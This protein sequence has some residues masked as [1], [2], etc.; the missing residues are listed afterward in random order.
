[1]SQQF[2]IPQTTRGPYDA[3][4][5]EGQVNFDVPFIVFDGADLQVRIKPVG[6]TVFGP[7]LLFGVDFTVSQLAIP[8]G[9][10]LSLSVGRSAG[11][12]VRYKGARLAKRETSV[13]LGGSV[14]SSP[15]EL[16]LDKVTVTLQELRRDV[17]AVEV[18]GDELVVVQA[19]LADHEARLLSADEAADLVEQAQ[20]AVEAASG[21]SSTAQ[22]YAADAATYAAMLGANLFDF[23]LESD[24]A[25]PG[26]D[27]S[28]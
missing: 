14:R 25:T 28:E 7:L 2:P 19:T 20:G 26:Y 11:D 27:W 13:T 22:G 1:M 24:P 4:A 8:G 16:E 9:A 3:T 6:E 5:T 10:R 21:F 15:L 12:V 18:I 17:G 23:A